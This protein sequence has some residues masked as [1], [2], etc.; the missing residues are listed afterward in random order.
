M[1]GT[2]KW[3]SPARWRLM[4]A[5]GLIAALTL[6]LTLSSPGSAT[7]A[8]GALVGP[9]HTSGRLILDASGRQVRLLGVNESEMDT[10]SGSETPD[11]CNR[12]WTPV[13]GSEPQLLAQWGFNTVRLAVSWENLEPTPPASA[14]GALVHT[15]NAAY[16]QA[17]DSAVQSYAASGISVIL[18][19]H[20]SLM[21]PAFKNVP[22]TGGTS[23]EGEGFPTWL[24]PRAA[25]EAPA[26]AACE[27][28]GDVR[29]PG[30]AEAPQEGLAA[31]WAMLA[32][33]YAGSA[34][35]VGA[36]LVN[37]IDENKSCLTPPSQD[38]AMYTK[39][40]QAVNDHAPWLLIVQDQAVYSMTNP[41]PYLTT[42][43]QL[44]NVVYSFHWYPSS[45]ATGQASLTAF[46]NEAATL[47]VPVYVGEFDAFGEADTAGSADPSWQSDLQ[48][49]LAQLKADNGSWTF[50]AYRGSQSLLVANTKTPK[51]PL[52]GALQ[53]GF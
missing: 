45:L 11:A 2:K 20:Q 14:N 27:F 36:D 25:S 32:K 26:D 6:P 29:E 13:P 41:V 44:P 31:V 37:E 12:R 9:L 18:D 22:K 30:A 17:L 10:G 40:G 5:A 4:T 3:N 35:V 28:L 34:N 24:Y 48:S 50:W 46:T 15:W 49:T 23:C 21:S 16:L 47:S 52:L 19:A 38:A 42:L 33:R 1:T 7:P 8:G 43:P 39:L 51:Q 53:T